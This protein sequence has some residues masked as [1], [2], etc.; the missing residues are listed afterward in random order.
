MKFKFIFVLLMAL[1]LTTNVAFATNT[2]TETWSF[3]IAKDTI[4]P[5]IIE[6]SPANAAVDVAPNAQIIARIRDA[7]T[8]INLSSITMKVNG[9]SVTFV[10]NEDLETG[11]VV[12]TYTPTEDFVYGSTVNVELTFSDNAN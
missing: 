1:V 4:N 8:G 12:V 5:I 10:A 9:T 2:M 11:D 3:T 6:R 7:Q